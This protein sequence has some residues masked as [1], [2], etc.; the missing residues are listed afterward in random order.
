MKEGGRELTDAFRR[1]QEHYRFEAVFCNVEAGHEKGNVENK[2]GY[3]RINLLVPV[4]SFN[5]LEEYNQD[6]LK[7][8]D[9]DASREHYRKE[10]T[11]AEL[12]VADKAALIVCDEWGYIPVDR[13]GAQLLFL[14]PGQSNRMRESGLT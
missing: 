5:R 2:V 14:F 12:F 8:C 9:Q 13:T 6:L 3:H 7:R 10:A 11:I 4:P 1:F